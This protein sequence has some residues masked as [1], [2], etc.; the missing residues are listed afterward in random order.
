[1]AAYL[2]LVSFA[3]G[4]QL[5]TQC[6][7]PNYYDTSLMACSPCASGH[8]SSDYLSCVCPLG[9]FI[10]SGVVNVNCANCPSGT[11]STSDR[12]TCVR[13]QAGTKDGECLCDSS[14]Y[15]FIEEYTQ[16]GTA[17]ISPKKC[18]ACDPSTFTGFP[19]YSCERCPNVNMTRNSNYQCECNSTLYTTSGNSCIPQSDTTLS[20]ESSS[21]IV[22]YPALQ[23]ANGIAPYTLT[24][25][26]TF[27]Y[28]YLDSA[29][30]C[31]TIKDPV[32]CQIL[33]NLCV[34]E[35]YSFKSDICKLYRQ[36][37][38]SRPNTTIDDGW[39]EG[40]A[41][42][43]Y[44]RNAEAILNEKRVNMQVT[45]DSSDTSRVNLLSFYLAQFSLNGTFIGYQNLTDQLVLCPH[46]YIVGK[47]YREFG[48]NVDVTCEIDLSVYISY[49]ETTF[50]ELYLVDVNNTMIDIPILI[51]NLVF[52]D[53][54]QPNMLD[55]ESNWKLV[56]RFFIY[57]NVSGKVGSNGYVGGSTTTVLQYMQS[58]IIQIKLINDQDQMIYCP[59]LILNYRA[60]LT[61]YITSESSTDGIDFSSQ[62]TM[63]TSSF[64]SVAKGVF[65]GVNV[66]I[67]IIAA[68]RC[69]IWSKNNPSAHVRDSYTTKILSQLMWYLAGTWSF[70]CFWYLMGVTAYWFIFYKM[71][72]HVYVLVPP[73]DT[74]TYNYLPFVAVLSLVTIF[75]FI[76][77]IYIIKSQ[78]SADIILI[79]R[80]KPQ[81]AFKPGVDKIT[82]AAYKNDG[83]YRQY[84]SAWRTLMVLNE[85]AELQVIRYVSIELTLL[86]LLLFLKGVSWE[87]SSRAKPI[88]TVGDVGI[89][90]IPINPVLRFFFTSFLFLVISYVQLIIR[91]II[92][93][94]INTPA[95][96]FVDLCVV[97]NISIAILDDSLHGYYIHGVTPLTKADMALEELHVGLKGDVYNFNKKKSLL[98]PDDEDLFTFEIYL[99]FEMRLKYNKIMQE[100]F[101]R[102]EEQEKKIDYRKIGNIRSGLNEEFKNFFDPEI[103]NLKSYVF[104]KSS[105]QR[106]LNMPP[107][108][109]TNL[110]GPAFFYKDP[111]MSF[112]QVMFMG[113]EFSLLLMDLLVFDIMDIIAGNSLI[114]ALVTFIFSKMISYV[115]FIL[116]ENNISK[117]SMID[118]KFLV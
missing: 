29:Y 117:K 96:N 85:F 77:I 59:L 80:E 16:N 100:A 82:A 22:T 26:S 95:R 61:S 35:L 98:A 107:A 10:S 48:T 71:Q 72:Y 14:L 73:L 38:A 101:I 58:A 92:S 91:K 78:T 102:K 63:D 97:S 12:S 47:T 99:P 111:A 90:L 56:R 31:K 7:S 51:K 94:W 86:F 113:K 69:Y 39:R 23:T 5:N 1:M 34:L 104:E 106:V 24:V 13:C 53:G 81:N 32:S 84:V 88:L 15:E 83:N 21:F 43:Y 49:S 87:D 46:S 118:K 9:K 50:Y 57:D 45:F 37:T 65:I 116:G 115:R 89:T 18:I 19:S 4:F 11:V 64:W 76:W 109:M 27:Q 60:R 25:S 36:I 74:Y 93:P 41:W 3:L 75:H 30:N 17:L 66:L 114:S 67:L 54:T 40:M 2:L 68:I 105:L 108:E 103:N 33:A 8:P 79:D 6:T 52:S 44:E 42:I 55:A 70:I 62:Y 110:T 112:E 20:S 28:F